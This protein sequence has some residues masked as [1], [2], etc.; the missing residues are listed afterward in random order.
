MSG[1]VANTIFT[2]TAAYAQGVSKSVTSSFKVVTVLPCEMLA[3]SRRAPDLTEANCH[4]GLGRSK[5]LLENIRPE[6]L[7]SLGLAR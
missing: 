5:Q 4:A 1:K 3:N 7:V 6:T 2:L